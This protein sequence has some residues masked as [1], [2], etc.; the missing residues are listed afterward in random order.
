VKPVTASVTVPRPREEV[1]DFLDMLG[2]HQAFTDHFLI[3]WKLSGPRAGI[4]ARACMRVRKPG[5]EDW[6]DLKVIAAV[7]PQKTVE[8]SIGANRRRRTRGTY[9]LE[10]LPGGGTEVTFELVW[11]EAPLVERLG[12][13]L[14]RAVTRHAN[15]KALRRLVDVLAHPAKEEAR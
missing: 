1:Y 12:A 13:P 2:N 15:A 6:L 11:L 7:R 4:G 3:D 8:E 5:P 14:T 10:E 9:L